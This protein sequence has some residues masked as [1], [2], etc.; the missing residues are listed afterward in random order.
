MRIPTFESGVAVAINRPKKKMAINTG[1]AS[2]DVMSATRGFAT[3]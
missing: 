1:Y 3:Q 2:S